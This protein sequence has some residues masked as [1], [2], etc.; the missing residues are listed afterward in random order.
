MLLRGGHSRQTGHRHD[1][2]ADDDQELGAPAS[3]ISRTGTT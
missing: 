3:R 2:A 1:V